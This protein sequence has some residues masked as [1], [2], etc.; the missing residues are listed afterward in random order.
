MRAPAIFV[1]SFEVS[2]EPMQTE[3]IN[4]YVVEVT[5]SQLPYPKALLVL[6]N[7]AILVA[8]RDGY[9]TRIVEG[10]ENARFSLPLP[11]L[12]TEGQGECSTF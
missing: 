9:I 10:V 8:H 5:Q 11:H 1:A 7:D 12:F 2:A 4:N 6:P 3:W